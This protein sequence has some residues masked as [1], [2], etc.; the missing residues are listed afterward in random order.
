VTVKDK[1][2]LIRLVDQLGGRK[3]MIVGDVGLD[4]YVIGTVKR[5]S[6]EA[7]V[8]IVEVDKED[9]KLGLSSNVAA[10]VESLGSKAVLVGVVGKDEGANELRKLLQA[11][12]CSTD[13][14]VEDASRPTTRKLR[15]LAS[16]HH[17]VRVDYERKKFLSK[18]V[19]DRL[20]ASVKKALAEVD[21][22]IIEDYAKGVL[23]ERVAQETIRMAHEAGK[24]VTCDPNRSSPVTLYKG[25]DYITPNSDEALALAKHSDDGLRPVSESYSEIGDAI[26]RSIQG[27]AVIITRGKDGMSIFSTGTAPLHVPTFARSVFDVTGAGD[28]VIATL[29]IALASGVPLPEACTVAN[30]AAGIVVGKPGCVTTSRNEIKRYIEEHSP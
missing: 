17:V 24:I 7:P 22:V 29:T 30:F 8:P 10:N 5:I 4:Q 23:S 26:M 21:A 19:E 15:I 1:S 12:G 18:E 11:A 6:P 16:H 27:K 14:L 9:A 2:N 20:L 3:I 25:V 28:T 13:Y